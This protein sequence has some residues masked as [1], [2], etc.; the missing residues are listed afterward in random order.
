MSDIHTLDIPTKNDLPP[1]RI[2]T[3]AT[4]KLPETAMV[5]GY[6][7]EGDLYLASSTGDGRELLW[8]LERAKKRLMDVSEE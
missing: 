2:L 1:D 7:E 5:I 4:G 8:L 3:A 6:D